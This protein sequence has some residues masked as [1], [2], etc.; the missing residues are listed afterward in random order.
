MSQQLHAS[1]L[2]IW[3]VSGKV[4]GSGFLVSKNMVLTCAHVAAKALDSDSR[5]K[6]DLPLSTSAAPFFGKVILQDE[7][8]DIAAIEVKDGLPAEAAPVPLILADQLWEHRFRTLGF[9]AGHENGTWVSGVL[10]DRTGTGWLQIEADK[11]HGY[12][13]QPGFSGSPVWDEELNAV[14]GMVVAAEKDEKIKAAFC[15]PT[16]ILIKAFPAVQSE[17]FRPVLH[18]ETAEDPLYKVPEK[19]QA[20][21]ILKLRGIDY[22]IRERVAKSEVGDLLLYTLRASNL[23][24]NQ[25]VGIRAV[26]SI[27]S[28]SKAK[29][30]LQKLSAYAKKMSRSAVQSEHLA[31]TS[32]QL[33]P[34]SQE[35][36]VIKEWIKGIPL[37][38]HFPLGDSLQTSSGLFRL[39]G[40]AADIC[41]AL[42]ALHREK[43]SVTITSQNIL[44]T[45]GRGAVLID[46]DFA[47]S[48]SPGFVEAPNFDPARDLRELAGMIY[49]L[50]THRKPA[51]DRPAS[52][53][54]PAI[55]AK[56]DELL[57]D[58]L[59][60]RFQKAGRF[61]SGLLEARGRMNSR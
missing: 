6:M 33:Q 48:N 32:D 16:N 19:L 24:L 3:S 46:H 60:G 54:N 42:N 13:V 52:A 41:E 1:L 21:E 29:T 40:W 47:R 25:D 23:S 27:A 22:L 36:W 57:H 51:I 44:S 50:A 14:V 59:S 12:R 43:I 53:F 39:A 15:I 56:L 5:V 8:N 30:T 18:L 10:R 55:P 2:R 37:A 4:V 58:G 11:Q 31:R 38:K 49:Q 35:I 26:F 17:I 7:A 61:K 9:P 20:G 34:N 28:T 45:H